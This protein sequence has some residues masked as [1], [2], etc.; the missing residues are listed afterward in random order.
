MEETDI[1]DHKHMTQTNENDSQY[2][3]IKCVSLHLTW[4]LSIIFGI[5]QI[6]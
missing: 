3:P 6:P 4:Q 1:F 5:S 2:K